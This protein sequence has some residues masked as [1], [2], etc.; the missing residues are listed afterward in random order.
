MI[1]SELNVEGYRSFNSVSWKPGALNVLIGPNGSGKSNLLRLLKLLSA[2]AQRRLSKWVQSEGGMPTIL[3]NGRPD[4]RAPWGGRAER[5]IVEMRVE[6]WVLPQSRW[7]FIEAATHALR[8]GLEFFFGR[9]SESD[10]SDLIISDERVISSRSGTT[11][12][13]FRSFERKGPKAKVD[14]GGIG[15]NVLEFDEIALDEP[16]LALVPGVPELRGTSVGVLQRALESWCVVDELRTD[17][18]SPIRQSPVARYEKQLDA[19]G[20]NLINVLH[21]LYTEDMNFKTNVDDAMRAAFGADLEGLVF[22]PAA[23]QRIQMRVR[24]KNPPVS[25]S[26]ADLSDGTLRFLFLIALLAHPGP[27]P[28]IAIDE[29][30]TGLH[31]GMFRIIAEYAIEASK[32]TQILF[33]THSPEFLNAF[34]KEHV[35]T[36]TVAT[37]ENGETKLTVKTADDLRDWLKE[38]SLGDLHRGGTLEALA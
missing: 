20:E 18:G 13:F 7:G 22:G 24:W 34:P 31:P 2:A 10:I 5:I 19:N 11:A 15:Q 26:S 23:D 4:P 16:F 8:Y 1:V 28:L 3:W 38:F 6:S 30:E 33:T 12:V 17:R 36:V 9:T 14:R 29:P 35:P 37:W 21:T 32:R 25:V 27:P